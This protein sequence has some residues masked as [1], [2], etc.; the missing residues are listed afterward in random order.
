MQQMLAI[1]EEIQYAQENQTVSLKGNRISAALN[2]LRATFSN[3]LED[4]KRLSSYLTHDQKNTI[5]VL[6]ANLEQKADMKEELALLDHLTSSVDD[7]LTLTSDETE[8]TEIVDVAMIVAEVC[9][10]YR[11]L[12]PKLIFEFDEQ[13]ET[14][15]VGKDRW[16]Q[17]A[18]S[19]LLS[20]AI[21]YG[22]DNTIHVEVTQHYHS[23]VI[24]IK[25]FGL[26][27]DEKEQQKIF[28]H[29]YRVKGLKQDGYGIGLSV[30]RHVCD[31]C[32]GY[33]FVESQKNTGST[34]YLS[35]PLA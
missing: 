13:A 17:R 5:A 2:Q 32:Q 4:Y 29:K 16:I 21:K 14:R 23:V 22:E 31:L 18:V 12:Y 6:K 24:T 11:K 30:V 8:T 33:I 7:L 10:S 3:K 1:I 15:I 35:F 26:G 27:M 25:D 34:F 19:N 28:D 9:D 20:N